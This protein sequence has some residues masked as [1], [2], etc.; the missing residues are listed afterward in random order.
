[1]FIVNSPI[2]FDEFLVLQQAHHLYELKYDPNVAI[3]YGV[4]TLDPSDPFD[5]QLLPDRY[6]RS[7]AFREDMKDLYQSK[8]R[9][10]LLNKEYYTKASALEE[11]TDLYDMGRGPAH[12]PKA[13][14]YEHVPVNIMPRP[15]FRNYDKED[16]LGEDFTYRTKDGD[17]VAPAVFSM[18]TMKPQKFQ[19]E[20]PYHDA[21]KDRDEF[22]RSL[23]Y[24]P[25]RKWNKY[26]RLSKSRRT[27]FTFSQMSMP[28]RNFGTLVER[29]DAEHTEPVDQMPRE[30]ELS[31]PLMRPFLNSLGGIFYNLG[32]F[33]P[34]K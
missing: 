24:K 29:Q 1:M 6:V 21:G 34:K 4:H 28:W 31:A 12:R 8:V 18:T 33:K 14:E 25:M 26:R 5:A 32:A 20:V 17:T 23:V 3:E 27:N 10:H 22:D 11:L 15:K 7:R 13:N 19:P 30:N 16:E 9:G 2:T